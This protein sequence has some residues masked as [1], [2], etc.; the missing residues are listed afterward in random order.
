MVSYAG[1]ACSVR[2]ASAQ[3]APST[4]PRRPVVTDTC[5]SV[6][7]GTQHSAPRRELW[8]PPPGACARLPAC[9]R[10]PQVTK[11]LVAL[12]LLLISLVAQPLLDAW[13]PLFCHPCVY[14]HSTINA[15]VYSVMS[16]KFWEAFRRPCG[17]PSGKQRGRAACH[18]ATSCSVVQ[19]TPQKTQADR[20]EGRGPQAAGSPPQ[21]QGPS[22]STF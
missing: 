22:V 11:M 4:L 1:P 19:E 10:V 5:S 16:Q 13:V 12:L 15:V 3:G 2:L 7:M 9:P 8:L 21:P 20:S 14:T 18:T 17:C 6:L